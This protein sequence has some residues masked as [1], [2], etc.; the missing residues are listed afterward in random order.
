MVGLSNTLPLPSSPS[1]SGGARVAARHPRKVDP[2]SASKR[3]AVPSSS[4]KPQSQVEAAMSGQKQP[5][6]GANGTQACPD[7]AVAFIRT[8]YPAKTAECVAADIGL[9]VPTVKRWIEGAAKPSWSGFSRMILAYGPAFLVA[10][11]PS[12]PR[13]LDDAYQREQLAELEAEQA[14]IQS[15]I[16]ALRA[17][18]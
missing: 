9:P 1:K 10:V 17:N 6:I 11:F 7:R 4:V 3:S 18:T 5:N 12:R 16:A 15:R 8:L 14:R 2:A 13:W